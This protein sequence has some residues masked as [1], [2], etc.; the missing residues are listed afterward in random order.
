MSKEALIRTLEMNRLLGTPEQLRAFDKTVQDLSGEPGLTPADLPRLFGVFDDGCKNE[1]VMF[2]LV[3]FVED[4]DL[5]HFLRGFIAAL[6]DLSARAP[7]W[8]K[9]FH[10]RILNSERARPLFIELLESADQ[11]TRRAAAGILREIAREESGPLH[12]RAAAVLAAAS[13]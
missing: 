12:D 11:G 3:H 2:G 5:T 7:G 1:E 10:Y 6:K 4:F 8:A 9:L 13:Q